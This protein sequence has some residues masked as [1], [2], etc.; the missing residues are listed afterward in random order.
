MS[1][2][3]KYTFFLFFILTIQGCV[4]K[5]QQILTIHN[6]IDLVRESETVTINRNQLNGSLQENFEN[7][8]LKELESNKNITIQ[9]ID[10]NKDGIKDVLLFQPKMLTNQSKRLILTVNTEKADKTLNDTI[11]FS[12]FV[13]ER[14][15]DFAWENDKVAFRTFGPKSKEITEK[16]IK[17]GA[18]SS[19]IDCW[20]KRVEY[21]ILNK[22]YKKHTNGTGDYHKDTGEGVDNYHVGGSLGCGGV[23]VFKDSLLLTSAN[24]NG[25]LELESGAIQTR[26]EL[27]YDSWNTGD[28][29]VSEVKKISL[30]KGSHLT[31][32][33]LVF[34]KE[35]KRLVTGFP[36]EKDNE[37][38]ENNKN[39]GWFSLWRNHADSELGLGI[40]IDPKYIDNHF[41]YHSEEKDK[42]HFFIQ[43]KPINNKV[44]YYAGFGWKK[45]KSFT[46][47]N[48]WVA[49]LKQFSDQLKTPILVTLE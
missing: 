29:R 5:T 17:G 11:S 14:L 10:K 35:V 47:K 26:F 36:I 21:P 24:F 1:T 22:W 4:N 6:N 8:V 28:S 48:D 38:L 34:D 40:V 41:E 43:L 39:D 44:V 42:S 15:D 46:T 2:L 20:L 25:Y 3:Y 27:L 16:G 32:F 33:E 31:R 19:G 9:Y 23:G 12:R 30:N 45:S 7:L 37:G 13:P 18:I 49:Y